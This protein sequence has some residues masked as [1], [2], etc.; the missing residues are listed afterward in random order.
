VS[1]VPSA[2]LSPGRNDKILFWASFFTLI[3][4]GIGFSVRG[5]IL[6]DWGN[7]FGFTQSELGTITGGGLIGFGI[8]IIF[9]SFCADQ[10]GYGKLMLVAFTLHASS[11]IVTFAAT[12]VYAAYGKEGAYWCL[13]IG[14]WLFALGNGTCEAVI[15]PLTATLFSKNKTHWLNILH[16]GWPLGLILGALI[17]LGFKQAAPDVRWEIKLGVFLV[18]VLLYGLMMF[19][20]P[21]PHSEAKSSG[22]SMGTMVVTLVSPILLF[23]FVLHALVGYVELGTDSW[24]GNITERVLANEQK[25]LLAFIW[26]N[27]L[28]FTLRFFAGP[29]V[30]KINPVGLLFVSAVLGTA[31]LYMLGQGFTNEMWPWMF[32]VTIYGLGK[33]FYWPTL[34]G[35]ISERFPKGGALALGISGGIGMICAGLLGGPGIGYKQDLFAVDKI[36]QTAPNTYNRYVSRNDKGEPAPQGFPILTKIVPDTLPPVAGLDNAKLKVHDDWGGVIDENGKRKEGKKTTLEADLETLERLEKEGKPVEEKL[37]KTLTGLKKWWDE[38]GLPNYNDDKP[39]LAESRLFGAKQALLYTAI[40]PAAL[41][42]GFLLLILYFVLTGGYKQVHLE[43]A[44]PEPRATGGA[45]AED[46][47]K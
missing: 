18:P 2:G 6:K 11:A 8:A 9:F 15:N 16:A 19:N 5:F 28:M 29:I 32:A 14:M 43:A 22:V 25:A 20:R 23:L 36:K 17:V 1:S 39:K 12:P 46:W 3:A 33:T 38:D 27:A 34:L 41:A 35:V 37:K 45:A 47:G 31:G 44:K 24:I 10:F 26:T 4:A 13:Y 40:V 42:I 21:F 30:E 7:Q